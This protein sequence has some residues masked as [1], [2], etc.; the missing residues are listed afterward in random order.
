LYSR[1]LA[2]MAHACG[3][4]AEDVQLAHVD[5]DPFV[6]LVT[7]HID[8]INISAGRGDGTFDAPHEVPIAGVVVERLAVADLDGDGRADL[9]YTGDGKV[10]VYLQDG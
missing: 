5:A 10:A 3:E 9:A 6:D 7:L 2:A 8:R 4:T 1:I